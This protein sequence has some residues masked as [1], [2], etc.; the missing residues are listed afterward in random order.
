VKNS[1]TLK[2][3]HIQ[4]NS[5]FEQKIKN[6]KIQKSSNFEK[7]SK[8]CFKF[9]KCSNFENIYISEKTKFDRFLL[10]PE[11]VA[12]HII[13]VQSKSNNFPTDLN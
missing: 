1:Q 4:K 6:V 5:N 12:C 3:V 2:N 10:P 11:L 13:A 9:E 7:K 8:K